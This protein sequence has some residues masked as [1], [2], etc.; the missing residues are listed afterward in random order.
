MAELNR[1]H[2]LFDKYLPIEV[3]ERGSEMGSISHAVHS[4]GGGGS[5][6]EFTKQSTL[7]CR[8]LNGTQAAP[9]L[10]H[11][12]RVLHIEVTDEQDPYF[13]YYLDVGEHEFHLLKRDQSI[14]V[15]FGVFPA[16]L[17]E[18]IELCLRKP[19]VCDDTSSASSI[20]LGEISASINAAAAATD[21]QQQM[22]S[23]LH[24]GDTTS[25]NHQQ[26][27]LHSRM[28]NNTGV[29]VGS[30]YIAKLCTNSE[31]RSGVFSIVE[32]NK[33]K[34]LTH[35]S[36]RLR[37][38]DDTAIKAYLASRLGFALS[39]SRRQAVRISQL[40]ERLRAEEE[41]AQ[42]MQQELHTLSTRSSVDT[43]SLRSEHAQ[44]L[45]DI[46]RAAMESTESMRQRHEEQLQA[47]RV[48]L[49]ATQKDAHERISKYEQQIAGDKINTPI[50]V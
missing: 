17:I 7:V 33:F 43:Q 13:L 12:E 3:V 15:D 10:G 27:Q 41:R 38:G 48:Q 11:T 47:V 45:A 4:T 1:E 39:V 2:P 20:V 21:M 44:Q 22:H 16:K 6:G 50:I 30:T 28:V 14:L 32:A 8:I 37:A 35:I 25:T 26:Q 24:E 31:D 34:Q 49:E 29:A 19:L 5:G 23:Q 40:D 9:S 46:Q 18:L 36:L 42:T